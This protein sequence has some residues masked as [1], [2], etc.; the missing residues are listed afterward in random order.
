MFI[1][2]FLRF[3]LALASNIFFESSNIYSL[4]A[5]LDSDSLLIM[6][7]ILKFFLVFGNVGMIYYLSAIILILFLLV[8]LIF[9]DSLIKLW[10]VYT[11]F[12]FMSTIFWILL[13]FL[14]LLL[15][16]YIGFSLLLVYSCMIYGLLLP[17]DNFTAVFV[18]LNP[19]CW[20]IGWLYCYFF[21]V[22]NDDCNKDICLASEL[23]VIGLQ[24][25]SW[26]GTPI[27]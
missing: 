22:F 17:I 15:D 6:L 3:M 27:Y 21:R 11:F 23:L 24:G 10:E 16:L 26:K 14:D 8:L 9:L 7:D 1:P 12:K 13:L 5:L 20:G 25:T 18:M 19:D 4:V 2:S